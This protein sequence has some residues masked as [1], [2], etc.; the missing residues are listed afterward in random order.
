M[1]RLASDALTVR[2]LGTLGGLAGLFLGFL[3]GIWLGVTMGGFA[4]LVTTPILMAVGL[5]LGM[6]VALRLLAR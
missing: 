5:F 6:R 1:A 3:A 2:C 4:V